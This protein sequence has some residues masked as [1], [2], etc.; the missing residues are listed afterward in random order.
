MCSSQHVSKLSD[1]PTGAVTVLRPISKS[2]KWVVA[3]FLEI[4]APSPENSGA[5]L[6]LIQVSSVQSL[7]HSVVSESLRPRGP[8][9]ARSPCP[10]ST[11][12]ACSDLCPSS[13]WCHPTI[14]SSLVPFSSRLQS[15]PASGN[16]SRSL[17]YKIIQSIKTNHAVFPSFWGGPTLC[18]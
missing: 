17:A 8:Q 10:S 2:E 1:S 12:W 7:S 16:L 4:S 3:Q 14:S 9:H 5:I 15:F 18:L 11:L 13:R 6:P